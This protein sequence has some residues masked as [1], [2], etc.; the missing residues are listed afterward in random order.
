[1]FC[2]QCGAPTQE[3]DRFC[4][5]CGASLRDPSTPASGPVVGEPA[6]PTDWSDMI[7]YRALISIPEVHDRIAHATAQA[8][9]P[10]STKDFLAM[11]D[12]ALAPIASSPVPT[13]SVMQFVQPIYERMGI[14]TGKT[15]TEAVP[16]PVGRVIV[17]V[18]CSMARHTVTIGAVHQGADGVVLEATLPSSAY[19][20]KTTLVVTI[21]RRPPG[22]SVQA[23]ASTRAGVQPY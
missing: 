3:G 22:T 23:A 17:A 20:L 8:T 15:R 1:M 21:T 14:R 4:S 12:K 2:S 7:D 11:A 18:L 10:L 5:R 19:S 16:W 13:Q 6:P 9:A